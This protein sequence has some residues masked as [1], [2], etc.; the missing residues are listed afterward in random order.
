M[1]MI[2]SRPSLRR[3]AAGAI[4]IVLLFAGMTLFALRGHTQ[5]IIIS[6]PYD[7]PHADRH[8]IPIGNE[9][10]K[11]AYGIHFQALNL[12]TSTQ[13]VGSFPTFTG[14]FEDEALQIPATVSSMPSGTQQTAWTV[15]NNSGKGAVALGGARSGAQYLAGFSSTTSRSLQS[16]TAGNHA[17]ASSTAYTIQFYY[18]ATATLSN[19][20]VQVGND[21]TV[22]TFNSSTVNL[23]GPTS[24]W[25]KVAQPITSNSAYSTNASYGIITLHYGGSTGAATV[26]FDDVVMYQGGVDITPPSVPS[27]PVISSQTST[28]LN[29]GWTAASGGVDGGGYM[30][31]RGTSD[32]ATAPNVNGIYKVG[33]TVAAG[34]SVVYIGTSTSFTDTGLTAGTKY[35]YR[36]YTVD[37][38]FNY[39][40]AASANG[41]TVSPPTSLS[42]SINPATYAVGTPIT[43]NIP[44]SSGG[45]AASYSVSPALP[46]GLNL[47]SATGVISGT[48]TIVAPSASYVV[49]AANSAGSTQATVNI[50]VTDDVAPLLN[51]SPLTGTDSTANPT[52][53]VTVVDNVGVSAVTLFFSENGGPNVSNACAGPSSGTAQNGVWA[54]TFTGTRSSPSSIAYYVAASDGSSN[55]TVFP[56][57]PDLYTIGGASV[58]SGTY[59]AIS[60]NDRSSLGGNVFVTNTLDLEGVVIAGS[61]T[62]LHL[63][64]NAVVTNVGSNYVIGNIQKDFCST[65]AF[66]FPTGTPAG[67]TALGDGP[68]PGTI[69]PQPE[70]SPVSVNVTAVSG[71]SSLTV[72]TTNTYLPGLVTSTAVSRYWTLT[73][74][75]N[76]TADLTFNYLDQDVSGSGES[77]YQVYKRE[78]GGDTPMGGTVNADG[79]S[80]TVLGISSFSDW[81]VGTA[82]QPTGAEVSVAGRVVTAGGNGIQN[83][84]ITV[85]GTGTG[86]RMSTMTGPF[87]YFSMGGLDA[88]DTYVITVQS[89]RF[90]FAN[91]NRVV[92]LNDSVD[93]I[94]FTA[95]P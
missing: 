49:T 46:A 61:G 60:L 29:V 73:E 44:S 1:M 74:E 28:A 78:N 86:V 64:C 52:L 76:I 71:A 63:G 90:T 50:T 79:N 7:G 25:T 3:T 56:S 83:A 69:G 40:T 31:V 10:V 87:G 67:S 26:D 39:S 9:L 45:A 93:D 66:S 35:F 84:V 55:K 20:S 17:I 88:G 21:G 11:A 47:N 95:N 57:V 36:I 53:N 8:P 4:A 16:P 81:G 33:N 89:K 24:D 94:L 59:N 85:S 19:F 22:A 6:T 91:P 41:T 82:L 34:Q 30:V 37:K 42:Y 12:L 27:S 5:E 72:S 77:G 54:C 92:T 14:G 48:P 51:F 75:G 2:L 62:T 23:T 32:P 38:A 43:N 58:P 80:I 18:R 68:E 65:G 13:S 70:Y 15:S